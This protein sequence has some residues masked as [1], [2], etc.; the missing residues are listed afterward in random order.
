[1]ARTEIPAEW[2]KRVCAVLKGGVFG[3]QIIWTGSAAA[4]FEA[5]SLGAWLRD[6]VD[7]IISFLSA[8]SCLGCLVTMGYPPG[9]TY[10]F[11]FPFKGRSFYGKLLLPK[12]DQKTVLILSAHL[13]RNLTLRCD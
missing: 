7:S 8:E 12:D 10:E 11:I 6:G 4:K 3:K 13:P 2:R 5:D 9:V 1:M